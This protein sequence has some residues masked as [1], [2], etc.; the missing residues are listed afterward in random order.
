M[1]SPIKDKSFSYGTVKSGEV[2]ALS[3][4]KL[5]KLDTVTI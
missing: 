5:G 1:Y 2:G 3:V 4:A